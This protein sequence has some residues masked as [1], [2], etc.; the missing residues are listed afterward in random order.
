M[1]VVVNNRGL[2][3]LSFHDY[4]GKG[5]EA[6]VYQQDGIAYKCYHLV[7]RCNCLTLDDVMFLETLSTSCILLPQTTLYSV[8]GNF[9]GYTTHYIENLGLMHFM[10]LSTNLILSN[11]KLLKEDCHTLGRHQVMV[12]D[13]MPKDTRIC[14]YSFHEGLYFVD[15]GRYF[16]N[17]NYSAD[18]II[19]KNIELVDRFIFFRVLNQYSRDAFGDSSVHF[20]KLY[21]IRK[22][23]QEMNISLMDFISQDIEE[24][25]LK[26]YVK[27]KVFK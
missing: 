8:F 13:F 25:N 17:Y 9:K 15:P 1:K 12:S 23:S 21:N 26:C 6:V 5:Q 11:F 27:R 10:N 24:E 4:I 16:R 3:C 22:Q 18:E 19:Q 7:P 14:N 2:H 20:S